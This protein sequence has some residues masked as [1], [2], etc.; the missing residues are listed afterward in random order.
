MPAIFRGPY[1]DRNITTDGP[2]VQESQA[3]VFTGQDD[4]SATRVYSDGFADPARLQDY[5]EQEAAPKPAPKPK[6]ELGR[7]PYATGG[8]HASFLNNQ[9]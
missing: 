7:D 5:S 3:E 2:F 4:L 8:G 6:W 1:V 9:A